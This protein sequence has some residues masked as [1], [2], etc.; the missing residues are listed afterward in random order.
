MKRLGLS[1]ACAA[2][3]LWLVVPAAAQQQQ[4]KQQQSPQS[5][6]DTYRQLDLF[7]EVFERVRADYVEE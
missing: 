5:N 7:G 3:L 6:A 1:A 4:Q 2:T